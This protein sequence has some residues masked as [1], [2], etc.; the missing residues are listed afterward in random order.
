MRERG[1]AWRAAS[2][3]FLCGRAARAA[4][5]SESRAPV[6][7]GAAGKDADYET[8]IGT[9]GASRPGTQ[10]ASLL[11]AIRG[12]RQTLTGQGCRLGFDQNLTRIRP[13]FDG[14]LSGADAVSRAGFLCESVRDVWPTFD[15]CWLAFDQQL[16]SIWPAF[17]RN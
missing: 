2:A 11:K 1:S 8:Q 7:L 9:V 4:A 3:A 12:D 13:A 5:P 10:L 14:G 15:R 17:D 16:A 6:G